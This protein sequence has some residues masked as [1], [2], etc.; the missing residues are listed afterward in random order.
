M[1]TGRKHQLSA[2]YFILGIVI[3]VIGTTNLIMAG[4]MSPDQWRSF[5]ADATAMFEELSEKVASGEELPLKCATPILNALIS[6]RPK[7]VD[8]KMLFVE[9]EDTM[10]YTYSTSHFLLHYTDN[11][12]NR[13]YQYDTQTMETG[14]PDYIYHAGM[15]CD[16]VW[17]HT[18][19]DLGF[20]PPIS[21][22]YYNGGGDGLMDI[23]FIDFPAYGATVS[24]SIQATIPMTMTCYIFIE[25]DYEGFP[26]YESNRL[27]ALRVTI[28][29]EFFH[30]VQFAIDASELEGSSPDVNPAWIEMSA[31]FMEDECYDEVNDYLNYLRFFY[32]VPQW[33]IRTGTVLGSPTINYWRNLHM[34]GSVVFPIFLA[35]RYGSVIIRDIWEG[36]GQVAGPNWWL[37]ADDA[38][39]SRS[40][41]TSDLQNEFQEF[42]LWNLFTKQRFKPGYFSEA[43]DYDTVN[44]A[45][46]I[47]SYPTTLN[48]VDSVLPDNLGANYIML[49]NVDIMTMGLEIEFEPETADS[50]G[51]TL[52]GMQNDI[53]QPVMVEHIDYD[54][55]T[56]PIQIP[57]ASEFDRIAL[58]VSVLGGNALQVGYQLTITYGN[59][60]NDNDNR[61]PDTYQLLQNSPNPFNPVTA[62]R[63]SIPQ[64]GHVRIEVVN[65][66]GQKVRTLADE[67]VLAG[68]HLVYWDGKNDQGEEM[69]S[70]VYFYTIETGVW[71]QSKMMLLLR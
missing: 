35:E 7:G 17:E 51:I 44:L 28:A 70:A 55:V 11:G 5:N 34:Y 4:E 56:S 38:I 30:T 54:T 13:V 49:E 25:N 53:G 21:D 71:Q 62:I 20:T 67:T 65:I 29:H 50:W 69:P 22:G 31:V 39:K 15:I 61:P 45:A 47:T 36:C 24:D 12:S 18:V 3:F 19:G 37:A 42:A 23:Y 66:L 58:I 10:T 1:N 26:G 57:N 46:R 48:P 2:C 52:V 41:D 63:Y 32:D 33:S 9:R 14:V 68:H 59:D 16:S 8:S 60:V 40:G 64:Y 27:N 6:S 43:I